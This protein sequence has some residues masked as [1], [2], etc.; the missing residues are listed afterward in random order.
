MVLA[1]PVAVIALLVAAE[2]APTPGAR[3]GLRWVAPAECIQPGAL[4]RAVEVRLG[5]AVF[6]PQP[7]F[8]LDGDL[9]ASDTS[10]RWRARVAL[11]DARGTVLGTR[12]VTTDD[13]LCGSID[14]SL[15][16]MMAVM[17]DP[18]AALGPTTTPA[19][20]V[21]TAPEPPPEPE[22]QG[23]PEPEPPPVI[24][25]SRPREPL[26][27]REPPALAPASRPR[28]ARTAFLLGATGN[29]GA[30]LGPAAGPFFAIWIGGFPGWPLELQGF[31]LA[32]S[33]LERD[34]GRASVTAFGLG[35][36][37]CPLTLASGGWQLD[38]CAGASAMA[39]WSLSEGFQQSLS[40]TGLR[41]DLVARARLRKQWMPSSGVSLAATFGWAL[42]RP[43]VRLLRS[44]GRSELLEIGEPWS[45]GVELAWSFGGTG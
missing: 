20:P 10:P 34:G 8:L 13:P 7:D 29:L 3:W 25:R 9:I 17:I 14:A 21:A 38:G 26:A 23:E 43:W 31:A 40:A 28:R 44:D 27:A 18:A 5:R 16:L 24:Q 19:A 1:V 39:Q 11:V 2:P 41:P 15:A 4:S 37:T 33:R 22:P 12:D 30:G 42:S 35:V 45:L 36:T 6:G 32:P